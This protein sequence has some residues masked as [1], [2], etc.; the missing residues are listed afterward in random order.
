MTVRTELK[1][2]VMRHL[3]SVKRRDARRV[4]AEKKRLS[5]GNPHVVE[6]FHEAGDPYSHLMVQ[7]LPEFCTRYDIDFKTHIVPPPEDWA[8]P[9]RSKL[10][11]YGRTDAALLA[12]RIGLNF[13]DPGQTPSHQALQAINAKI[14]DA[15]G[16][17]VFLDRAY[18][19]GNALWSGRIKSEAM[20]TD[21]RIAQQL[22]E[23]ASRRDKLGHYLGGTLY[24]A[25]EWY[26]GPDRLH[27]LETRLNALGAYIGDSP[28]EPMFSPPAI[29]SSKPLTKAEPRPVLHWYLSFRSPYTGI[30]G[31]RV[32]ALADAYGAELKLRFV[33]PM[34]MRSLPV[35]RKKGFY[36]MSDVTREAQHV[37]ARFGDCVDPL[38]EPVER[39]YAILS[40]AIELGRGY[41]FAQSFLHG[42]WADGIDA[43]SDKGLKKITERAGLDW[44]EMKSL[45]GGDHWQTEAEANCQEMLDLGIWGVPSFRVGY[46]AIWGQDRLWVIEEALSA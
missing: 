14:T 22:E 34:A 8:A 20:D 40:R 5:S 45:I 43:G 18:E 1:R 25:G 35:P 15:D 2:R 3:F 23:G 44:S 24:Y 31:E 36:I 37:G 4:A 41:A 7:M 11:A 32:K 46:V 6:Y 27:Y 33:L 42:V 38:G 13:S 10:D 17:A 26:W 28:S 12:K 21:D 39:G 29:T 30:V 16:E 9:E 19:A